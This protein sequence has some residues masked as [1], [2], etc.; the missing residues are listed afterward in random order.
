MT[1][2]NHFLTGAGIGLY[3]S[4]PVVAI[5]AAF[6]SHF[7]LD[8]LPHFGSPWD[9]ELG[10]RVK[11]KLFANVIRVDTVISLGLITYFAYH[12]SWVVLASMFA[13]MLPDFIW[14]YKFIFKEQ[15]GKLP[16]APKSKLSQF[17]KDIQRYERHWGLTIEI[18]VAVVLGVIVW[19]LHAT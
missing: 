5:P 3:V 12:N 4:N 6:V 17:H 7:V 1:G 8:S 2:T 11:H 9:E 19:G 18:C 13:A 10:R 16:P 14:V 15:F